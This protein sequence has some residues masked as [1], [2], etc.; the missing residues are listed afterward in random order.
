[1]Y[2]TVNIIIISHSHRFDF[3]ALNGTK[4]TTHTHTKLVTSSLL[5]LLIAAK[6]VPI[7]SFVLNTKLFIYVF[8]PD[9][10]LQSQTKVN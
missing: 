8:D 6:N 7:M 5:E 4:M 9:T 1:M 3:N 2:L 10:I